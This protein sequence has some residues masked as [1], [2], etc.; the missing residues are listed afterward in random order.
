MCDVMRDVMFDVCVCVRERAPKPGV[1]VYVCYTT[2]TIHCI[3][4]VCL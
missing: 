1:C 2:F 3:R 4:L